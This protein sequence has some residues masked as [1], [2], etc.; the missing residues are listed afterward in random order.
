M[1]PHLND[2]IVRP[3]RLM[4][5]KFQTIN[6]PKLKNV[7][8]KTWARREHQAGLGA[9]RSS[10]APSALSA[11]PVSRIKASVII[12]LLDTCARTEW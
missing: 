9:C 6:R 5:A 11:G 1:L 4:K 7:K 2:G 8:A 10:P 12:F 3:P